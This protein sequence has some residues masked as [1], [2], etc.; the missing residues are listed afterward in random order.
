MGMEYAGD[1]NQLRSE[2]TRV[3]QVSNLKQEGVGIGAGAGDME[4][5]GYM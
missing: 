4:L 2:A 5:K 1:D 3:E